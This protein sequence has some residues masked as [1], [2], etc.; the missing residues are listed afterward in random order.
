MEILVEN[1]PIDISK[2]D[3]TG[4]TPLTASCRSGHASIVMYLLSQ[5]QLDV[6]KADDLG[7][8][9]LIIACDQGLTNVVECL[10]KDRRT[11]VNI[12]NRNNVTPLE[13][14][15]KKGYKD[16]VN[17]LLQREN[18]NVNPIDSN[19]NTL[20]VSICKE[21]KWDIV[22]YL[23]QYSR[24]AK[25]N[26][27]SPG[28][29]EHMLLLIACKKG[30]SELLFS[31]RELC[32]FKNHENMNNHFIQ[33]LFVKNNIHYLKQ[34]S[35]ELVETGYEWRSLPLVLAYERK[36]TYSKRNSCKN[37]FAMVDY[38]VSN[39]MINPNAVDSD[40]NTALTFTCRE[41][42]ADFVDY[43][44]NKVKADVN[45]CDH[46]GYTPFFI[47]CQRGHN[48]ITNLLSPQLKE[49]IN[50]D[51]NFM[52]ES[53]NTILHYAIWCSE[54]Y[55][56]TPLHWACN[57]NNYTDISQLAAMHDVM[58]NTQDN[59]GNTPLHIACS[60]GDVNVIRCLMAHCAQNEI[61][62]DW[63]RT[64]A[65]VAEDWARDNVALHLGTNLIQLILEM[66]I[67]N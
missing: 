52:D 38:L 12:C 62:N 10:V 29:F 31:L 5:E 8:I 14:A 44:V 30:L 50:F 22:K 4:Q 63:R 2:S 56:R 16:V 1:F 46:Q 55:G 61:T 67:G 13:I 33:N 42:I 66:E 37:S 47:S 23:A 57:S 18:I 20:L 58:V 59:D 26:I 36:R 15:C 25:K 54:N 7:N 19:G 24:D 28:S 3:E 53:A 32:S 43:L 34:H 11:Y 35:R 27:L 17:M 9:P 41:N 39:S 60:W 48:K 51:I 45:I 65:L 40:K 49:S 64:P 6:N 21:K